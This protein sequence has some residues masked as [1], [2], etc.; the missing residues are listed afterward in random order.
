[1]KSYLI[2][3]N[4]DITTGTAIELSYGLAIPEN[5]SYNMQA[6]ANYVV[7]FNNVKQDG[8]TS[9]KAVAPK[10][11]I[12]TGEGPE[13]EVKITSDM[14]GK[15]IEEGKIIT[16]TATVKNVGKKDV[17]NISLAGM[18]PNKTIYI[19]Y[20]GVEG[21]QENLD[22][23]YDESKKEYV[24]TIENLKPG[25][26]KEITYKVETKDLLIAQ[27]KD[28]NSIIE[29]A[30]IEATAIARV[31]GYDSQFTSNVITNKLVQ[32]YLN[33]D[34]QTVPIDATVIR[35]E[36]D[37][38]GYELIIRNVNAQAKNNVVVTSK[39]PAGLA[40]E[41][42]EEPGVYNKDTNTVTWNIGKIEG[43]DTQYI[44]L[45]ARVA[46]IEET[47]AEKITT[48]FTIKTADKELNK[49]LDIIVVAPELLIAQSSE[50]KGKVEEGEII[51][52]TIKIKNVGSGAAKNIKVSDVIPDG[53]TLQDSQ[54][55]IG[56][57]KYDIAGGDR[58]YNLYVPTLQA[59]ETIEIILN[60]K[61]DKLDG[62]EEKVVSNVAKMI[63]NEGEEILSNSIIHTIIKSSSSTDDPS[64]D[65][66]QEG[67]YRISGIAWIDSNGDGKR[68][69][70]ETRLSNLPVLLINSENGQI[71]TDSSTGKEKRQQTSE[72]GEYTFANL[73]P[74]KYMVIFLY[75]S[76]NYGVT[77]YK[78]QGVTD[79]KN[80]DAVEMKVMLDGKTRLAGVSDI[81]TIS[82]K[83]ITNIDIGLVENPK[84]D[85]RLDKTISRITKT[86]SKESKTYEYKDEK[87]AKLDLES[88]KINDTTIMIEY[89]IK[90]TNEGAIAG[91]AKKIVDYMPKDMKF[92]SELNKDWYS[93]EK[94]NLYN[95]SLANTLI[96]PGETKEI[97]LL[98]TKKM[99]QDNTGIINNNAEIYESYNDLGLQDIDS[100]PGNKV[101]SEDDISN[102]DA[103]IGVKT[104]QIY[105]YITLTIVTIGILGV[106]IYFINKKVLNVGKERG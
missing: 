85:L 14:E 15:D 45:D 103:L 68:D 4:K 52:Y 61:A 58:Q 29:E 10:V 63:T 54:Y 72:N 96:M 1:M 86:D 32:G 79:N 16:Y 91:Y 82:D 11:G 94:G 81:I 105:L 69:E 47:K 40:F 67:T 31:E 37:L 23:M 88:K 51:V 89:K 17:Q 24:E 8:E 42:V 12:T 22:K 77:S 80:S 57:E 41:S 50:T 71:V 27:D 78:L 102:A 62:E 34:L 99:T 101:Q 43:Y 6:Y 7:Y 60:A 73:K 3:V 66:P 49:S 9:E 92:S 56:N 19:Y 38:I 75:D 70:S 87:L 95:A 48:N 25:E 64:I 97:T 2:V 65:K 55:S 35:K 59:K 76:G 39:L 21:T 100:T 18:V 106:G 46:N 53:L 93:D 83:N 30:N 98:L 26:S 13:L 28:G 5:L 20:D 33:I 44:Y 74:G 36:G 90:I 84:F 104:G